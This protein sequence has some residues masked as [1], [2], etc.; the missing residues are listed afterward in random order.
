MHGTYDQLIDTLL[1]LLT[2]DVLQSS[3]WVMTTTV[4]AS[5]SALVRVGAYEIADPKLRSAIAAATSSGRELDAVTYAVV[6][7]ESLAMQGRI[8]AAERLL[9]ELTPDD[10][11]VITRCA[12]ME[13]RWFAALRERGGLE[14]VTV[15]AIPTL[16]APGIAEL[17]ASA[18][19]FAAE[20]SGR[21]QLLDGD[22][23]GA[24]ASFDRLGVAAH[25]RGVRNPSFA[26]WRV[27]RSAALAGL[28]RHEEGA[29]L[30]RQNLELARRFGSPFAIAEGLASVAQF[31]PPSEQAALL[32]EAIA[33]ISHTKAELLRC[34]LLIDLGFARHRSGDE[35]AA[36]FAFRDGADQAERCGVTRLAGVAGSGLLAC[37]A[38]PRRLQTSGLNSLTPAEHRVVELAAAGNT[39]STI[40]GTLF[41]NVKTVESH[42]TRVYKKLGITDRAE[43]RTALDADAGAGST[44]EVQARHAGRSRQ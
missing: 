15:P 44:A 38:R 26:P 4:A 31:H 17:G 32:D 2:A 11:V 42:L 7:A 9:A 40:A 22:Y 10:D 29:E 25:E 13:L 20:L 43:L 12:A 33:T 35:S 14:A 23:T 39:N 34:Q 18:A 3:E 27:G 41:I 19:W 6:L 5:L 24:L 36:R 28:G 21:M 16:S 1:P 8:A 37:G 30:A